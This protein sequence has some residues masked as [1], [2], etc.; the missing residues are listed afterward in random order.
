MI[1]PSQISLLPPLHVQLVRIA[2]VAA[3][4]NSTSETGSQVVFHGYV[5][6]YGLALGTAL[7]WMDGWMAMGCDAG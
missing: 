7:G 5:A 1:H 4:R 3:R 6:F 2:S